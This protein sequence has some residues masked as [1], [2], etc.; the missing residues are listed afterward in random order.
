[1]PEEAT[2]VREMSPEAQRSLASQRL[3][4]CGKLGDA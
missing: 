3:L 2:A 4:W 1:M